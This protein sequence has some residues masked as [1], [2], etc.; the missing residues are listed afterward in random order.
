MNYLLR[1]DFTTHYNLCVSVSANFT[2]ETDYDYFEIEDT[3]AREL[4]V[5]TSRNR[6]AA[7]F[8]NTDKLNIVIANYDKFITSLPYAFQHGKERCDMILSCNTNRYFILGELKDRK[9]KTKVRTK[10]K[11]QLIASLQLL[12]AV[13]NIYTLICSKAIKRCCFFNKQSNSPASLTATRAFNRLS[14]VFSDGFQ[15]S[16]PVIESLGFEY[17]EYSGSQTMSLRF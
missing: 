11:N 3:T 14:S 15:M 17:F 16:E 9:P 6:G 12:I 2:I 1:N 7:K 4:V 5:H 10:A 13:P 8:S